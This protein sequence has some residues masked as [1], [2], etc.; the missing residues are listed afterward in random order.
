MKSTT[1][2]SNLEFDVKKISE[3]FDAFSTSHGVRDLDIMIQYIISA[4]RTAL[5][6]QS[7]LY[8]K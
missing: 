2:M 1:N 4:N 5:K 6:I 8:K 7:E 3:H